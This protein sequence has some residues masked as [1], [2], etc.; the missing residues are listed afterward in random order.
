M[1]LEQSDKVPDTRSV[2]NFSGATKTLL[3][4]S[5]LTLREGIKAT[6]A[7]DGRSSI[8]LRSMLVTTL[9]LAWHNKNTEPGAKTGN[10]TLCSSP[11]G[12]NAQPLVSSPVD[13]PCCKK[14]SWSL[15][16]G[17]TGTAGNPMPP[18]RPSPPPSWKPCCA[19]PAAPW[20]R[21]PSAPCCSPT[22]SSR[23]SANTSS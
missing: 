8:V 4:L 1:F 10:T 21:A 16:A 14:V 2:K 7:K 5:R 13:A 18:P 3:I 22:T 15:T 6:Q 17:K 20:P 19:E 23:T 12:F 11:R 9:G